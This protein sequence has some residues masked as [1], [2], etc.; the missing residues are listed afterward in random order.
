MLGGDAKCPLEWAR[1]TER[2]K[3][4]GVVVGGGIHTGGYSQ[5]E[6]SETGNMHQQQCEKEN[7]TLKTRFTG[8]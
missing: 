5:K 6:K 7:S 1:G 3:T 4:G 2:E 8:S